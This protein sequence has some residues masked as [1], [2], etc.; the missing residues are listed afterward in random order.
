MHSPDQDIHHKSIQVYH[1]YP[2]D[3]FFPG[4]PYHDDW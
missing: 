4:T 3:M 1:D 2:V